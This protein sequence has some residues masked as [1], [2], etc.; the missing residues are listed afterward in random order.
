MVRVKLFSYS[1]TLIVTIISFIEYSFVDCFNFY[2]QLRRRY[3]WNKRLI[4]LFIF[5]LAI[6]STFSTQILPKN[7]F[8]FGIS[9]NY[10]QNK[11]QAKW[12]ALNF[13]A[14]IYPKMELG[15]KIQKTN[16][17]VRINIL[18]IL[19]VPIFRKGRQL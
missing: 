12:T 17:G 13:S 11:N 14:E 6:I 1:K 5:I 4:Q 16:A 18:E 3:N 10:S 9:E 19:C 7:G 15:L 2:L 8:R